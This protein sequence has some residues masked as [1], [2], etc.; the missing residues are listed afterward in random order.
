VLLGVW[1]APMLSMMEASIQHL[2]LQILT[3][4]IPGAA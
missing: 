3:S 1:P 4:K 2:L